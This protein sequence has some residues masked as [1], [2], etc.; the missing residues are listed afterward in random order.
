MAL[1]TGVL[2]EDWGERFE[3]FGIVLVV[4][5]PP[6]ADKARAATAQAAA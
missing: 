6:H 4:P 1:S 3:V 5:P 2:L